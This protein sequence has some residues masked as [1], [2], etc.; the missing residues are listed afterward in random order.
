MLACAR[1]RTTIYASTPPPA[2]TMPPSSS[3]WWNA[4]ACTRPVLRSCILNRSR[5]MRPGK[6]FTRRCAERRHPMTTYPTSPA[7][8]LTDILDAAPFA[9]AHDEKAALYRRALAELTRH[10][11]QRCAEYRRILDV[12]GYRPDATLAVEQTPFIPV[13]LFKQYDLLSVAH[14]D[15]VKTMTSSGTGGQSVSKIYLD[16]E[17]AARQTK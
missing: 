8:A 10:H 14:A 17:T 13:R 12:L 3:L 16:K 11:H 9:L 1:A 6:S 15:I 5:A 2:T 4:P 7:S